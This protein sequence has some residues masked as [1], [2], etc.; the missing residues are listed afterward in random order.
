MLVL[1]RKV[2]ESIVIGNGII[3]TVVDIKG[4]KVRIGVTAAKDVPVNRSE[5]HEAILR[6]AAKAAKGE[7]EAQ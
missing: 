6:E 1:S 7:A 4:E 2:N 3:V 5:V